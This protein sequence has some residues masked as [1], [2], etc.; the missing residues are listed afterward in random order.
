MD[1]TQPTP[2]SLHTA[3]YSTC[4]SKPTRRTFYDIINIID[5]INSIAVKLIQNLIYNIIAF[6][7]YNRKLLRFFCC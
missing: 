7:T 5:K 4:N 6:I 3:T 2:P 1:G